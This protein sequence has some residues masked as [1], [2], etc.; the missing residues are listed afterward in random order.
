[1][2][3]K[4]AANGYKNA[5]L[6]AYTRINTDYLNFVDDFYKSYDERIIIKE[7][8]I[9]LTKYY[10]DE[11]QLIEGGVIC[12]ASSGKIRLLKYDNLHL[13]DL[14]SPSFGSSASNQGSAAMLYTI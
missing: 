11:E 14:R 1:M 10:L 12:L 9:A 3:I 7:L 5:L 8:P 2:T 13:F 4:D 6:Q